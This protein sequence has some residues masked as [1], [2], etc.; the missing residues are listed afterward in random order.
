MTPA[1]RA[2]RDA[3]PS[4]VQYLNSF[5]RRSYSLCVLGMGLGSLPLVVVLRELDAAWPSWAW[6]IAACFVWPHLAYLSARRHRD[7]FRAELRNYVIDSFIAG[8]CAP[9]MHFNLLP[10]VVLTA[11]A[12]ADKLNTGIRGL[13][14]RSLPAMAG[15]VIGVGLLTGFAFRPA[16]SMAVVLASLPILVIH[17][18]AVAASSYGLVRKIQ[19]Q[20]M[21]LERLSRVDALTGLY[22]R[23]HWEPEATALLHRH[24][25][26]APASLMLVDL[27]AFKEI[28]DVHGHAVGD[29]VLRGIAAI[30]SRHAGTEGLAGRL[31]GDEFALALG[32]PLYECEALAERV[33][34]EVRASCFEYAPGLRCSISIGVAAPAAGDGSLRA[35]I[36]AADRALYRD[37]QARRAGAVRRMA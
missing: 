37:K 1:E 29:D 27:D 16:S 15:A 34:A 18:L 35:W 26:G 6:M 24:A 7:P 33:R 20:N 14:L 19:R 22:N 32:V 31:G 3:S 23:G 2:P 30:L 8:A 13:W 9:V 12:L 10:S 5:P 4:R 25:A 36:E 21:E 11:V 17:T 28:N